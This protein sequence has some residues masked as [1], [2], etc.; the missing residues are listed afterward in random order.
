M[1]P[2]GNPTAHAIEGTWVMDL[3][4]K[5][6]ELERPVERTIVPGEPQSGNHH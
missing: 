4:T 2:V 1:R 6:A 5:R 3:I